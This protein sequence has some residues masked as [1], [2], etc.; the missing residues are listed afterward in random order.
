MR[1]NT[2]PSSKWAFCAC[3]QPPN[4]SLMVKSVT[5]LSGMDYGF[6]TDVFTARCRFACQKGTNDSRSAQSG[7]RIR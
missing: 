3:F 7:A 4:T 1:S 6:P 2:P 5:R